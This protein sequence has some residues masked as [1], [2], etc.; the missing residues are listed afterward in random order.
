MPHQKDPILNDVDG[1][2][3]NYIRLADVHAD[4]TL[5]GLFDDYAKATGGSSGAEDNTD[6]TVNGDNGTASSALPNRT[7]LFPED[8]SLLILTVNFDFSDFMNMTT[9][10]YADDLGIASLYLYDWTDKNADS[11]IT[12]G[13]LALVTRG[14][15]WGTVQ[16]IRV[17][18]PAGK[19][20][21]VPVVGIYPSP[22]RYSYW[23][24]GKRRQRHL[25]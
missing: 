4:E 2:V 13:E 11:E 24:G 16:E 9:D 12:S 17:S 20:A 18:D 21:G 3:P 19:F 7:S 5:G 25:A 10:V 8:A 23:D 14:G 22:L 15:S 1:Y 6:D